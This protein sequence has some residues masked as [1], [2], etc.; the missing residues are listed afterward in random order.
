MLFFH[1]SNKSTASFS[2]MRRASGVRP[3][4]ILSNPDPVISRNDETVGVFS[5]PKPRQ[6]GSEVFSPAPR[7]TGIT[8]AVTPTTTH[9]T[10]IT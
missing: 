8:T 10:S 6:S 3:C 2:G 9:C 7:Y 4:P 1:S 5:L